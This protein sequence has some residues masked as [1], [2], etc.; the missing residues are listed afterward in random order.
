MIEIGQACRI[1]DPFGG[2]GW[3]NRFCN[4]SRGAGGSMVMRVPPFHPLKVSEYTQQD[5]SS[6]NGAAALATRIMAVWRE[7]G[8]D[9]VVAWVERVSSR[10]D[11]GS[12]YG[13]KSNLVNGL[14]PPKAIDRK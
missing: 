5:W 9:N 14:P 6:E 3:L 12:V 10:S 13:V 8:H 4:T 7:A 11:K 2:P 1:L